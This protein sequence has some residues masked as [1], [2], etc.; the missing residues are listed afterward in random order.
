MKFDRARGNFTFKAMVQPPPDF[1]SSGRFTITREGA[2]FGP[3]TLE[4]IRTYTAE[5]RLRLLDQAWA[6]GAAFP[7][8]VGA[9][10]NPQGQRD[11]TEGVI[12]YK[13]PAALASYY[14][15][16]ASVIPV[17]GIFTGIA[18]VILGLKGLSRYHAEP[19]RRGRLHAY[20]GIGVGAVTSLTWC[21]MLVFFILP[22][23]MIRL[24][25]HH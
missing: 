25:L 14:I 9:L 1:S 2:S 7:T 10:M 15:G 23:L 5:G 17:L 18:A 4:E 19:W 3:Y 6:E 22:W 20:A 12:P 16:L 13:N 24:N 11:V 8:T 21:V